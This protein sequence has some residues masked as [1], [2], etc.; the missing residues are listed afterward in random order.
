MS[1]AAAVLLACI[2]LLDAPRVYGPGSAATIVAAV[3]V[4]RDGDPDVITLGTEGVHVLYGGNATL[5]PPIIIANELF[6]P[7]VADVDGDGLVDIVAAESS[8]SEP[9]IVVVRNLGQRRFGAPEP[10]RSGQHGIIAVGD[11]TGEGH[12]DILLSA[13]TATSLLLRNDGSGHFTT[14]D[15]IHFES[16]PAVI[17]DIDGDGKADVVQAVESRRLM[18]ARG[19]GT[20]RFTAEFTTF[21]MSMTAALADLDRDGRSDLIGMFES[22][23]LYVYRGPVDLQKFTRVPA[24]RPHAVTAGDFNGDGSLDLALLSHAG[25]LKDSAAR[26]LVFLS[27]SDGKLVRSRDV[28]IGRDS[29]Y[30]GWPTITSLAS[31]DFNRDGILDLVVPG[32]DSSVGLVFGRG[33]G[34]FETPVILQAR[35]LTTLSAASDLN[36]DGVDELIGFDSN[37]FVIVGVQLA[38]GTYHFEWL[39]IP[40]TTYAIGDANEHGWRTILV[41]GHGEDLSVLSRMPD[42]VWNRVTTIPGTAY[43]L[44]SE[45]LTGDGRREIIVVNDRRL[46]VLD[47]DGTE[48]FSAETAFPATFRIAV[49]DV[50]RDGQQDL[51]VGR[52]GTESPVPHPPVFSDGFLSV[53]LGR[54]DA[55]FEAE[56]RL[57]ENKIISGPAVGEFDGDGNIDILVGA[58]DEVLLLRGDGRGGFTRRRGF[59]PWGFAADFNG[60]GILDILSGSTLYEGKRGAFLRRGSWILDSFSTGIVLARRAPGARPVLVG[61]MGYAGE[62]Y[63]VDLECGTPRGRVARH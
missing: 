7:F 39:P 1:A 49:A 16:V 8:P 31:A 14:E 63:T 58:E 19:D 32:G 35:R 13:Q 50:N 44:A 27:G 9:R 53:Y 52:G 22:G 24:G 11:L 5:A 62:I 55:T 46:R 4:D 60:D 51:I 45:D 43:G 40:G 21:W 57:I 30:D 15:T 48:R 17:G 61:A 26:V 6:A 41:S 47:A 56:N 54:G 25:T 3:D 36:G 10:I 42:G 18:V 38:D 59:T 37:R 33:D 2:P 12:P 23:D 34:T 28:L 29:R 20:G